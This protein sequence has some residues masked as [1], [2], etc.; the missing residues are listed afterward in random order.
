MTTAGQYYP[1]A[2]IIE[3]LL[4]IRAELVPGASIELLGAVGEGE[5]ARYPTRHEHTRLEQQIV[6][7]GISLVAKPA[8]NLPVGYRFDSEDGKRMFHAQVDGFTFNWL[9]PYP[10][11][12]VFRDEAKRLWEVYA[13]VARPVRVNRI[14]LRYINRIDVSPDEQFETY[15]NTL[16]SLAEG[17]SQSWSEFFM[18]VGIPQDDLGAM[19]I[20]TEALTESEAEDKIAVALDIDLFKFV[21]LPPDSQDMW[22][23]FEFLRDRKNETFEACITDRVREESR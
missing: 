18:R 5:K 13:S 6:R 20:L 11:W 15:L 10:R 23:Q 7:E 14:A 3:A 2:P 4:D 12:E 16:P 8:S 19:L 1:N 17:V 21:D 22:G 9:K